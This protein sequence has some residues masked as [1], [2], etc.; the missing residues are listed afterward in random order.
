MDA[1]FKIAMESTEEYNDEED[2][3]HDLSLYMLYNYAV[4]VP[5]ETIYPLF[6]AN[7]LECVNH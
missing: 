6:K 3:P 4:E 1:G 2:S 7:I 5:N